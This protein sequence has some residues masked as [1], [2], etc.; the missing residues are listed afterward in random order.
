MITA[1]RIL[2]IFLV[3]L[4]MGLG[5]CAARQLM[6]TPNIFVGAAA[7]NPFADVPPELQGTE[8]DILYATDRMPLDSTHTTSVIFAN[9]RAT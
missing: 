7:M 3:A 6:P 9:A 2:P 8:L 1:Q 4:P 5:A